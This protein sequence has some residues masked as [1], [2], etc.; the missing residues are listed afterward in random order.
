MSR[1]RA[2]NPGDARSCVRKPHGAMKQA[3]RPIGRMTTAARSHPRVIARGRR[4]SLSD[5]ESG[6]GFL[7]YEANHQA[8]PAPSRV[9]VEEIDH[10]RALPGPT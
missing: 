2:K 1:S 4:Q 3:G 10:A 8:K 7:S 9:V 6:E 5:N